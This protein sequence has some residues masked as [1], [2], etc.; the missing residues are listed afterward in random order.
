MP[1][2]KPLWVYH[3]GSTDESSPMTQ[4]EIEIIPF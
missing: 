2:H 3:E 1:R 4:K